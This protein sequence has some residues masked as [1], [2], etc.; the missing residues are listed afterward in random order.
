VLEQESWTILIEKARRKDPQ[1]LRELVV[2][3]QQSLF[4]F[5]LHL[6]HD[7]HVAE[8]L[9][10]ETYLKCFQS[11]STLKEPEAIV[12][13]LKSIA[14]HLFLDLAKSASFSS[15]HITWEELQTQEDQ[16]NQGLLAWVTTPEQL[17][18]VQ[19]LQQLEEADRTIL[20]LID[21][22]EC[23]YVEAAQVLGIPEG[24]VKSRLFR[25]REKFSALYVGTK[26]QPQS[27]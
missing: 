5:C 7:K 20:I 8:D 23:T 22:Q 26:Q 10:Q 3:T 1:A 24:T 11:L 21:I 15:R 4:V 16:L 27:S 17:A 12:G 2:R 18:A 6:S 9:A 19:I 13:W 25:A 14:R